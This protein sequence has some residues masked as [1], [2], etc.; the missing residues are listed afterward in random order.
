LERVALGELTLQKMG[1]KFKRLKY[2]R[3]AQRAF[4][5]SLNETDWEVCR[6]KYPHHCTDQILNNF[7]ILFSNWKDPAPKKKKKKHAEAAEEEILLTAYREGFTAYIALAIDWLRMKNTIDNVLTEKEAN[8]ACS[9]LEH[10]K[11]GNIMY[12]IYPNDVLKLHEYMPKRPYG[13]ILADV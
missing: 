7:V 2:L 4:L 3:I 8:R 13:L 12:Q 11:F 6:V 9:R 10:P 1:Y 5:T